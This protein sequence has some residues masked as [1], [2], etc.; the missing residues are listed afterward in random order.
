MENFKLDLTQLTP[1]EEKDRIKGNWYLVC[2]HIDSPC[3]LSIRRWHSQKY[4]M[5]QG[6]GCST[7]FVYWFAI[8]PNL[9]GFPK[10]ELPDEF[11]LKAG[12]WDYYNKWTRCWEKSKGAKY[13]RNKQLP[14]LTIPSGTKEDQIEAV[15][16][17]LEE[18]ETK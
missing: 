14:E 11:E 4:D 1:V 15:R 9:P 13:R 7:Y 12:E 8:P 17:I 2:D 16:K 6:G 3:D 10:S 18:L 5:N